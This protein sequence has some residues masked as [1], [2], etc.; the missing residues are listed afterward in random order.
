MQNRLKN[1]F[2][3]GRMEKDLDS[4]LI[5]SGV[6]RDAQNLK[7]ST[8]S[9]DDVGVVENDLSNRQLTNLDLGPNP[10]TL[11]MYFDNVDEAIYW[12][13]VSDTG[14]Y[15][16]EYGVDNQSTSFVLQEQAQN[17]LNFNEDFLITAVNLVV[18]SDNQRRFLLWNDGLNPPRF[19]NIERAK[20]YGLDNF[21]NEQISLIKP[22]PIFPPLVALSLTP[23]QGS[24]NNIQERFIRFAYRYQ[25]LD[26]EYSALSSFTNVAFFPGTFQYDYAVQ[27]N[28]SMTNAFNQANVTL[29]TGSSLVRAVDL[30]FKDDNSNTVYIVDHYIKSET[31]WADDT[32]IEIAFVNNKIFRALDGDQLLRLYDAV[33]LKAKAQEIINN[34]LI[35]ANYTEN[36]NI[37]DAEG[38]LIIPQF[39][40]VVENI[41]IPTPITPSESIKSNRDYEIGIAY[42][43]RQGRMTAVLTSDANTFYIPNARCVDQNRVKVQIQSFAPEFAYA[44]RFFVRQTRIDYDVLVPTVFYNDGVYVWVLLLGNEVNKVTEG[45]FL[46]VKADTQEVLTT[47]EQTRVIEIETQPEDFLDNGGFQIAGT[48]MK[49]KPQGFNLNEEDYIVYEFSG[50]DDSANK[51][52][53]PIRGQF[54][55]IELAVYYGLNGLDDMIS[56]GTYTGTDDKRY[57]IDINT[58]GPTDE[59]KWSDDNGATWSANIPITGAAQ[60]LELGVEV[61]FAAVTG[62]VDTDQWI[63]SAKAAGDNGLGGDENSK[64]YAMYVS[65]P[66]NGKPNVDDVILGGA[67]I[68]IVYTER[69]EADVNFE[70]TYIASRQYANLEEWWYGDNIQD[71]FFRPAS[72]I[73]FRRGEYSTDNGGN[74]ITQTADGDMI[75]IIRSVGTQNND[76]DGRAKVWSTF[77]IISLEQVVLLETIPINDNSNLFY[78]LPPTYLIDEDRNHLGNGGVDVDQTA[79]VPAEIVLE[80]FNCFAWGNGFE[81]Y[82]IKDLFNAT[83]FK[84]AGARPNSTIEDYRENTRIASLT[85]SKVYDQT[86]NFNGLNEFNLS[87]ANFKDI[88]DK[89]ESIQ[90]LYSRDT[91]L[92][93][94]Q[95]DKVIRIPYTKDL[96][97]TT[98]GDTN[99]VQSTEI[100]GTVAA[101]AGEYGISKNPESFAFYGNAIYFTDAR[102]AVVCR[103]DLDGITEISDY[104]MNDFFEDEFRTFVNNKKLGAFDL[105]NKQYVLSGDQTPNLTPPQLACDD[106]MFQEDITAAFTYQL[107]LNNL[108]GD[109]ILSY[110]ITQ[111]TANINANFNGA[112]YSTGIVSGI[113]TLEFERDSLVEDVVTVTVTP[114]E[115]P[116][117]FQIGN[118]CPTGTALDVIVIITNSEGQA[119]KTMTSRYKWG[120]S[121]FFAEIPEFEADGVTL[122]Q[123]YSGVEGVGR[124]PFNGETIEIQAYK[125]ASNDGSFG[126]P[127]ADSLGFLVSS[128][129]YG[130]SDIPTIKSL[131]TFPTVQVLNEGSIP[132]THRASFTFNR[133]SENEKL[134]LIWDYQEIVINENTFIY[135]YFDSSGSMASTEEPLEIM[136]DTLLQ[137]ALL[138]FYNNDVDLYNSR[139]VV[140]SQSDERTIDMLNSNGA[141]PAEA[142]NIISLVFQDEASTI[143]MPSQ[144]SFNPA[145]PRTAQYDTDISVFRDRLA[146]FSPNFYFGVIFQV[147]PNSGTGF[148]T[149]VNAIQNGVGNYAGA[150]G[151]SDKSEITYTYNVNDGDTPGYYLNLITQALTDLGFDLNP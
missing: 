102:R 87:T 31:G 86:T 120:A 69:G 63:V 126:A 150:N 78:E 131:A 39:N 92:V 128:V 10:K 33:P 43:D 48:Y 79:V 51:R 112:D 111:G 57:L 123:E 85:Y 56:G 95:E 71:D 47:V 27:S 144:T 70:R 7:V 46:Y 89:Y 22:P 61:T 6:Y 64:A 2:E 16:L 101:Y 93:V 76:T 119:G 149:F 108:A 118:A 100:L 142:S 99:V 55:T 143:Y 124:F 130:E 60:L 91:N 88:D 145:D 84:V 32:D 34:R 18:D 80:F 121:G 127:D 3:K 37:V 103:L 54:D 30:V 106:I 24:E 148:E 29:N 147:T 49:L 5:P 105:F 21:T 45:D 132:E 62:H 67:Q 75:L 13:V 122:F 125:D 98:S 73:W 72:E 42:L 116:A 137:D 20:T 11:G 26:G 8:A 90:R 109:V 68:R 17:V 23:N 25:Y 139:V 133:A 151:L 19:I 14:R 117:T 104:G 110:N 1:T 15:V 38:N 58:I 4:R 115:S 36:Y 140:I 135:I 52:D 35:L 146:S 66:A 107:T 97:L 83:N 138:P 44:Y 113:G 81:S 40:T 94:F 41:E 59:F 129:I 28:E 136:R 12:F 74:V 65:L 50:Y 96:L 141:L 53:N 134:Y 9:D 114:D 82:K 77:D